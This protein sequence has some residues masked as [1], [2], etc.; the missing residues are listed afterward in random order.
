MRLPHPINRALLALANHRMQSEPSRVIGQHYLR[1]WHAIPRNRWFNIY[2][3]EFRG[4]DDDRALHDHPWWSCSIILSGWY[5]EHMPRRTDQPNAATRA[6][7]RD[8]GAVTFRRP[9]DPHRIELLETRAITLF[10]T[11]PRVREWGFWCGHKGWRH[12]RIFTDPKDSGQTGRGC[13]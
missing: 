10:I 12:W 11:G 2:L 5:V 9:A 1:R 6:V 3:H 4:G 13:D 7:F 8:T